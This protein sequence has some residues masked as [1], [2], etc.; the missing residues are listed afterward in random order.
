MTIT[1]ISHFITQWFSNPNGIQEIV[2]LIQSF[3]TI[4]AIII[5]GIW[6][7]NTFVRTR[8]KYPNAELSFEVIHRVIS[9]D[10]IFLNVTV[11]ITNNSNVL[12]CINSE[13]IRVQQ[14]LPVLPNFLKAI[15]IK[16]KRIKNDLTEI[17]WPQIDGY[18]TQ[19]QIEKIDYS[20]EP[21]RETWIELEPGERGNR[22]Y[23]FILNSEVQVVKIY[24][25]YYNGAKRR[26]KLGW[27]LA[28]LYDFSKQGS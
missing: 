25:F 24:C 28:M 20:Y 22:R 13:I 23:D 2:G 19:E 26:K 14:V 15:D 12:L 11:H 17:L 18:I 3:I 8:Q 6:S 27:D 4:F 1:S 21:I 10:K 5:G 16:D 9:H 7:Y